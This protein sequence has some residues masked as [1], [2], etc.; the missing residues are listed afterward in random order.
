MS[1]VK[2]P[3]NGGTE[4]VR[5]EGF[6]A[7][8]LRPATSEDAGRVLHIDHLTMLFGGVVAVNDL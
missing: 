7:Q 1:D 8:N 4:G 5:S 3:T 2:R 6:A